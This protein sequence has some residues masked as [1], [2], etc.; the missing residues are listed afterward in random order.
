MEKEKDV[1]DNQTIAKKGVM[2]WDVVNLLPNYQN[3]EDKTTMGTHRSPLNTQSHLTDGR[4]DKVLI[5]KLM[6]LSFPHRREFL[7]KDFAKINDALECYPILRSQ[8]QV[9]FASKFWFVSF[10]FL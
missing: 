9:K 3:G 8:E 1:C 5:R 2:A 4:Q 7:I 6:D 10:K